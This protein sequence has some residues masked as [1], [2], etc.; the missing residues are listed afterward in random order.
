MIIRKSFFYKNLIIFTDILIIF[1]SYLFAFWIRMYSGLFPI[2]SYISFTLLHFVTLIGIV[3]FQIYIFNKNN[4]YDE[5]TFLRRI[6]QIPIIIKSSFVSILF[7]FFISYITKD[8]QFLERRSVII[9]AIALQIVFMIIIRLFIFRNFFHFLLRKGIGK[10]NIIIV[11]PIDTAEHLRRALFDFDRYRFSVRKIINEKDFSFK[12]FKN[13]FD[14]YAVDTVFLIQEK[15]KKEEI[16]DIVAYCKSNRKHIFLLSNMFDVAISKVDISTFEGIPVID[17]SLSETYVWHLMFKR[18]FDIIGASLLIIFLSPVFLL[19]AILIKFNSKGPIIF[20][21]KRIGRNGKYFNIYK[22]RTMYEDNDDSIHKEY[23]KELIKKNKK[24]KSG[25]FKIGDDPRI[26]KIGKFLRKYSLDELP[27]L[28]NVLFGSMSLVGP[29]PPLDYEVENYSEW[30][31]RRLSVKPG[32]T[33][34]WQVSGRNKIGFENM[35]LL[36][37]YYA[38][39]WT[40]W[41]DIRILIKTIPVVLFKKD[42]K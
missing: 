25:V 29:R 6:N 31:K 9:I 8:N 39:N 7:I 1:L 12:K 11:G 37:V 34:L 22:F 28:E 41:M 20:S 15:L 13:V 23:V 35:V 27:Q 2:N 21:Q 18:I 32:M 38:E 3:I 26:T 5:N 33:G 16:L 19:T 14:K 40:L 10:E 24:D 30:H 17:L 36:D 42:G 4:L